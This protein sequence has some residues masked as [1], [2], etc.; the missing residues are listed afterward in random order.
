MSLRDFYILLSVSALFGTLMGAYFGTVQYRI[1]SDEPLVTS[2]CFCP[3]CKATLSIFFQI[4][5]LSWIF[6]KGK[7]YYCQKPI[8]AKYPLIE[9]GFLF[10][11]TTTFFLYYK[12]PILLVFLWILFIVVLLLLYC[13][14]HFRSAIKAF[15]IFLIYHGIYG[16]LLI[17]ISY[18]LHT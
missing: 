8:P 11:Y 14:K 7:C 6:L 4:P 10:F 1:S 9:S 5:I 13:K 15:F 18:A 3:N 12:N 17:I 2:H 16:G